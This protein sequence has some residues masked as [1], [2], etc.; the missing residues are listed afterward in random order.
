MWIK[1][2][3][4]YKIG[5]LNLMKIL[6]LK[7]N[8]RSLV[9]FPKKKFNGF[10][11]ND[12]FEINDYYMTNEY[13]ISNDFYGI[14][15][16]LK[17]RVNRKKPLRLFIEH[18]VYFGSYT[19]E[20]E[21]G[22]LMPGIITFSETRKI[23]IN[24][25]SQIPV[26][27]IGPY[28]NYA[29]SYF[30]LD[31]IKE[32]KNKLGKI[33]LVFPQHTIEGVNIQSKKDKFTEKINEIRNKGKYDNV[34]ICLYYRDVNEYTVKYYKKCGFIPICAG[35][36]QDPNF[37]SRLKS[38]ILL[39]D[40]TIS[41]S[42]GTHIGYCE[43]LGKRHLIIKTHNKIIVE[44]NKNEINIPELYLNTSKEEK[45]EVENVFS[46]YNN[47]EDRQR[48]LEKYWGINCLLKNEELY[49]VFDF[50]DKVYLYSK[51]KKISYKEAFDVFIENNSKM[52]EIIKWSKINE[53]SKNTKFND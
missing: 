40:F 38:F 5:D 34:L 18:G 39:S 44:N 28:I 46:N 32:M 21:V 11:L 41:D 31:E 36:R 43:S 6:V 22:N 3:F 20:E 45:K 35:N 42:V 19:N 52:K 15:N 8:I 27:C 12:N 25:K 53:N 30:T 29:N 14:A 37:L 48:V 33:L 17:K 26:I 23:H 2:F 1:D 51:R 50:F 13:R 4:I 9:T 24:R 47:F 7:H 49:L 16:T 10:L